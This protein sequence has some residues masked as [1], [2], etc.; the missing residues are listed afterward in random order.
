MTTVMQVSDSPS[1][2]SEVATK[3]AT[4]I[5]DDDAITASRLMV[6]C[7]ASWCDFSW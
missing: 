2:W 7:V 1:V 3:I 6:R 5:S 4:K